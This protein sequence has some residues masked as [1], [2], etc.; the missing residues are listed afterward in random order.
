MRFLFVWKEISLMMSWV[1]LICVCVWGVHSPAHIVCIEVQS[2]WWLTS[3]PGTLIFLI[4]LILLLQGWRRP[5]SRQLNTFFWYLDVCG[6]KMGPI[7]VPVSQCPKQEV[8]W[9]LQDLAAG[10]LALLQH[11][12]ALPLSEK[13][14]LKRWRIM[15]HQIT[16]KCLLAW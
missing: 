15:R 8:D 14:R 12:G 13:I 7:F 3:L 11:A 10:D 1:N 5:F 9:E 6:R 4:A 2:L 16:T